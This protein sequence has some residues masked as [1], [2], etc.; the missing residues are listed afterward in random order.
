MN[1]VILIVDEDAG[2]RYS[3]KRCLSRDGH[4]VHAAATPDQGLELLERVVPDLVIADLRPPQMDG[5][6]FIIEA[7]QRDGTLPII[8]MTSFGSVEAAVAAMKAGANDFVEKP[9]DPEAVAQRVTRALANRVLRKEVLQFRPEIRGADGD[10]DLLLGNSP[11]MRDV[12]RTIKQ[13]SR[14]ASTTVLIEG[15]SGSGKEL[16]ARAIHFTS[17]RRN[18]PFVAVN[19]AALTETLLEA[20]LF[21]YEKGAFTGAAAAGKIGLFEAAD[22]G[23]IFLDEIGEMGFE[24]QAKLLRV[25]EDRKFLRVSGTENIAVDVRVV[26]STNRNLEERVREGSFRQDLFFRLK[27]VT[28]TTP[29]LRERKDDIP[30]LAKYFLD[31]FNQRFGRQIEGFTPECEKLM[32]AYLWPGN[33]RELKNVIESAVILETG[34]IISARHLHLDAGGLLPRTHIFAR[35]SAAAPP[36]GGSDDKTIA[37]VERRHILRV[38]NETLWQRGQAATILGIHRTTLANK[39]REYGLA[40]A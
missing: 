23:T 6:A 39:I 12:Y 3:L 26:A 22:G 28:I 4:E 33:V 21:G 2:I 34:N 40:N 16:I 35:G 1:A 20:E 38:L 29:P 5:L 32:L 19:C 17:S 7:R 8:A 18:Q 31:L 13:L 27:V 36:D 9:F 10:S 30:L 15:E 25:L 37:A 11:G 14:S 24:L